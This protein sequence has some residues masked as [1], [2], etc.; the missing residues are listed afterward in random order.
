MHEIGIGRRVR[1]VR[2]YDHPTHAVCYRRLEGI[3][4]WEDGSQV[5]VR[6]PALLAADKAYFRR[7]QLKALE[8]P[9]QQAQE[10]AGAAEGAVRAEPSAAQDIASGAASEGLG[11]LPAVAEA[12][13]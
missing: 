7:G 4:L 13:G 6:F 3:V 2:E 11:A 8:I 12:G 5:K 1:V 10:A 9:P